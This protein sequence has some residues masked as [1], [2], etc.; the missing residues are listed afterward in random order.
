[1]TLAKTRMTSAQRASL[2]IR[3]RKAPIYQ[4]R[5]GI[6][7]MLS[8]ALSTKSGGNITM[9]QGLPETYAPDQNTTSDNV[10]WLS[11]K[12]L[13]PAYRRFFGLAHPK[14]KAP[15]HRSNFTTIRALSQLWIVSSATIKFQNE[16]KI[17]TSRFQ[18]D[19]GID[20]IDR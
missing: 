20:A 17:A 18:H 5:V 3:L 9:G 11:H 1:M 10:L 12:C 4:R 19:I 13:S 2:S 16:S 14:V 6:P 15:I 7:N 8:T